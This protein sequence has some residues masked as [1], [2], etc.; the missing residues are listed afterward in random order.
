MLSFTLGLLS[1]EMVFIFPLILVVTGGFLLKQQDKISSRVKEYLF[2]YGTLAVICILCLLKRKSVLGSFSGDWSGYF[3]YSKVKLTLPDFINSLRILVVPLNAEI[4]NHNFILKADISI[5]LLLAVI[6][7]LRLSKIRLNKNSFYWSVSLFSLSLSITFF[8]VQTRYLALGA[9]R[10][11]YFP[12]A[13]FA[14]LLGDL[15][16]GYLDNS[17]NRIIRNC[18]YGIAI[19]LVI[20]YTY[21]VQ[22]NV[23]V[24]REAGA[25]TYKMQKKLVSIL[26]DKEYVIVKSIPAIHKGAYV[27]SC[28][29]SFARA[30]SPPFVENKTKVYRYEDAPDRL[31]ND[32]SHILIWNGEDFEALDKQ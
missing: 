18:V 23:S 10:F 30:L 5:S 14:F 27:F 9:G 11:W 15:F 1:S 19:S 17:Q 4:Y 7:L 26:G 24:W 8:N 29:G 16:W 6:L 32:K 25:I 31:K 28:P 3:G 21:A 20:F 12:A 2:T 13:C 22:K